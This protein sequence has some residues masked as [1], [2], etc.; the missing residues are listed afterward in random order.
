MSAYRFPS[1]PQHNVMMRC[2]TLQRAASETPQTMSCVSRRP[3]RRAV[4]FSNTRLC[5]HW[6]CEG[7]KRRRHSCTRCYWNILCEKRLVPVMCLLDYKGKPRC[8]LWK[9]KRIRD[10]E[11][12][13]ETAG[14]RGQTLTFQT[15]LWWNLIKSD[16]FFALLILWVTSTAKSDERL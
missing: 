1:C 2:P 12:I 15:R 11:Q 5:C 8:S 9:K 7:T 4:M 6:W 3:R 10:R 14:C 16:F 13:K